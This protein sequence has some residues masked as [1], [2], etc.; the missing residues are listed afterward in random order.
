MND[1]QSKFTKVLEAHLR[2]RGVLKENAQWTSLEGGRTNRLWRVSRPD[3]DIVVKLYNVEARNPL[4]PNDPMSEVRALQHLAAYNLSPIL[5]E[6]FQ[7]DIGSV[8]IYQHLEGFS[9]RS[10]CAQVATLLHRLHLTP[11]PRGLR[12]TPDGSDALRSQV[13]TIL[14]ACPTNTA[15]ELRRLEPL[16]HIPASGLKRLLHADPVSTNIIDHAGGLTLIDWQCPAIG[17]PCEDIAIFLSPAMHLAYRGV[18]LTAE[19]KRAFLAA[20]PDR[21][22]ID[23]YRRLEPWY[24]WRMAAYCL[25]QGV[26]GGSQAAEGYAAEVEALKETFSE[27]V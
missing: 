4:F 17:D 18:A 11:A 9:W 12:Q 14:S 3:G 13:Q 8:V 19:E 1:I 25:W 5:L 22:A 26:Q 15:D 6:Y 27:Q 16:D 10:D 7:A 23:R 20:Y 21:A 2:Q 24:H